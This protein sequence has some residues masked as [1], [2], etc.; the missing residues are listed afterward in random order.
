MNSLRKS[1]CASKTN[2]FTIVELMVVISIIGVLA[3]IASPS[4]VAIKRN[5]ELTSATNNLMAAINTARSEAMKRGMNAVV[6]PT[7]GTDWNTGI[8][9][10][11]DKNGDN[12]FNAGDDLVT[13]TAILPSYFT[14]T[15]ANAAGTNYILFNGSG[16]AR[17]LV[18]VTFNATFDIARND[19][20]D[21]VELLAQTRR[22]K[23]ATTGRLRSCKPTS[24]MDVDCS[25]T[26]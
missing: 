3:L 26:Y 13:Q 7:T 24:A 10:F 1:A 5:S 4:F 2:G 25:T 21:S 17:T 11:V 19:I 8:T 16:F 23:V 15:Q 22:L 18:G 14:I 6:A 12:I 9:I 20:T